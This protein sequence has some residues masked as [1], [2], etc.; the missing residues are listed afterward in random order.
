MATR[1]QAGAEWVHVRPTPTTTR[2]GETSQRPPHTPTPQEAVPRSRSSAAACRPQARSSSPAPAGAALRALQLDP[3]PRGSTNR[4]RR[5]KPQPSP[6]PNPAADDRSRVDPARP[7]D[8]W[9]PYGCG[10]HLPREPA[11]GDHAEPRARSAHLLR[12]YLNVR[13]LGHLLVLERAL[14][15]GDQGKGPSP[16]QTR[17]SSAASRRY[18][19]LL[20]RAGGSARGRRCW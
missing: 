6:P 8:N 2:A 1:H 14:T 4:Q 10:R 5:G 13:Q 7:L 9:G 11:A 3:G 15:P 12:R 17:I 20:F 19:W 18:P 16:R